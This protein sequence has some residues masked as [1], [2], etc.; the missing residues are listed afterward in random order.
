M[1]VTVV[2]VRAF[3][4]ALVNVRKEEPTTLNARGSLIQIRTLLQGSD[5]L[6]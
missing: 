1:S 3:G 4:L 6:I 2:A 5:C